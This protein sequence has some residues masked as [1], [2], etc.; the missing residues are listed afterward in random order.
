MRGGDY[1][2]SVSDIQLEIDRENVIVSA[3]IAAAA[4]Y[5]RQI[6]AANEKQNSVPRA[7]RGD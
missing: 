1:A 6:F 4:H 7:R 5:W 2:L 3:T